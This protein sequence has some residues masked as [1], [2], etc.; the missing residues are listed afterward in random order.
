MC[1][2]TDAIPVSTQ[3][4]GSPRRLALPSS[5]HGALPTLGKPERLDRARLP[6]MLTLNGIPTKTSKVTARS[7]APG[8]APMSTQPLFEFKLQRHIFATLGIN[9]GLNYHKPRSLD[10]TFRSIELRRRVCLSNVRK[11]SKMLFRW[12]E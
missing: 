10:W 8:D 9:R 12:N 5:S 7:A 2:D 4:L 11:C 1:L 3:R 6:T